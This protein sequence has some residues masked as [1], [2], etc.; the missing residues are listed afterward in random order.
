VSPGRVLVGLGDDGLHLAACGD[1]HGELEALLDVPELGDGAVDAPELALVARGEDRVDRAGDALKHGNA[2]GS[3]TNGGV[4]VVAGEGPAFEP[5]EPSFVSD[6]PFE[7]GLVAIP[8]E[9]FFPELFTAVPV[10]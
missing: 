6:I 7:K 3:S 4:L 2:Y 1:L 5:L 9:K 8:D 10:P